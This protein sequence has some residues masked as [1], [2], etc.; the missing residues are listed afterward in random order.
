MQVGGEPNPV[1]EGSARAPRG[2]RGPAAS[3]GRRRAWKMIDSEA[4]GVLGRGKRRP[5]AGPGPPGR[6][7]P[8]C[9]RRRPSSASSGSCI[10]GARKTFAIFLS[11]GDPRPSV[12]HPAHLTPARPE[13]GA[14][15]A[16]SLKDGRSD[17]L[18]PPAKSGLARGA[19][20]GK[21]RDQ[22]R[23]WL[24]GRKEDLGPRGAG[25]L[26]ERRVPAITA[27]YLGREF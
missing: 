5:A 21:P 18:A 4:R 8:G 9:T 19:S 20:L 15:L 12:H 17:R 26:P 25:T 22:R 3:Q 2:A 11:E 7:R 24:R 14:V 13:D 6:R 27:A 10:C 23:P 1:S 16:L